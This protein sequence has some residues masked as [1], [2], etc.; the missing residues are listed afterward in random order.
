MI[1]AY[2]SEKFSSIARQNHTLYKYMNKSNQEFSVNFHYVKMSNHVSL[3][4][5]N[6]I[7]HE[8][9]FLFHTNLNPRYV[10]A[11]IKVFDKII[12]TKKLKLKVFYTYI[13]KSD[14]KADCF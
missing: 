9:T 5:L 7:F 2:P 12:K 4:H 10:C 6:A 1:I 14:M 3:I 11:K 8:T 13:N